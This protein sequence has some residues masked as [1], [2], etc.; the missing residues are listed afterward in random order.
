VADQV[1]PTSTD[2]LAW[3]YAGAPESTDVVKLD[4]RYGLFIN[5]EFAEPKSGRWFTTINPATEDVAGVAADGTRDDFDRAIAA[6]TQAIA[7]AIEA[8]VRPAPEQWYTFKPI[9]PATAGEAE[10]LAARARQAAA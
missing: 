6:A 7:S 9:W 10:A 2:D 8:M 1:A 5:G 4:D 3:E